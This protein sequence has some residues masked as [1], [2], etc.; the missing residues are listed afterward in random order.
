MRITDDDAMPRSQA[1]PPPFEVACDE[2]G[3]DGENLVTGNTDV[4]THAS[5]RL[6]AGA[7]SAALRATED[8]IKSP[9]HSPTTEYKANVLLREKHRPVLTWLLAPSGPL[10]GH[11]C[12]HLTDKKQFVV[13][14]TADVLLG[15]DPGVRD[16][17]RAAHAAGPRAF[18]PEAWLDFLAAANQLLRART[19][20]GW[21]AP[22]DRFFGVVDA[23][24]AVG[25]ATTGEAG[26][27]IGLLARTRPG[28]EAYRARLPDGPGAIP[29]LDPLFPALAETV[30]HW[31]AGGTPVTVVHDRQNTLTPERVARL[32]ESCGG[33]LAGLR[34]VEARQDARVQLAD[35][36]AG[37]ARKT[38]SDE[39]AGRGDA[40]L[41]ALLRPFMAASSYWAAAPA[42]S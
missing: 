8:R 29:T 26:A 27:F 24:A 17:A 23:L 30:A 40:E 38:A 16:L 9:A 5:V 7:A 3:S 6:D 10:L 4:F 1:Q 28:A 2:S 13:A 37:I 19:H 14:R 42:A 33:A 32:T 36:L 25:S 15:R 35:F 22:V 34:F 20:A 18:G 21:D 39:L 31:S 12:V 41:T 11:A